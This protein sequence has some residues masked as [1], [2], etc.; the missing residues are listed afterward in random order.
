MLEGLNHNVETAIYRV[1]EH[2]MHLRDA[3]NRRLYN[4]IFMFVGYICD[5]AHVINAIQPNSMDNGKNKL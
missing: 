2:A 1:L 4:R 3:I 5:S